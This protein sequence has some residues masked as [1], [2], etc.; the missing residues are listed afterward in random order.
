MLTFKTAQAADIPQLVSL[1]RRS[2]FDTEE[3]VLSFI[4]RF[5]IDT[6][7]AGE[8][9][10]SIVC[11]GYVLPTGG[12]HTQR[13]VVSC[14]YIYALAV[15]PEQRGRGFG[16]ELTRAAVRVSV[17]RGFA[18]TALRPSDAGLFDFYRALGFS[19]LFC[20]ENM[21]F[22]RDALPASVS[23][24]KIAPL[25]PAEYLRLRESAL[26]GKPHLAPAAEGVAFQ[27]ALGALYGFSAEECEGCAA[28]E[29]DGARADI[30]EL[31]LSRGEA[32]HAVK[33]ISSAVTAESFHVRCPA[34]DGGEP[35][36]M[37]FPLPD[38]KLE[39]PFLG[40]S[41]D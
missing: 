5:G 20:A 16:R 36:G 27:A 31:I 2:F 35:D 8:L 13:G 28:I 37:V 26:E 19:E 40:L 24:G 18:L 39:S 32:A 34:F 22:E 3:L 23:G 6:C 38:I 11:A 7:V 1:W 9:D 14:S 29:A 4:R 30:K 17:E 25:S 12:L 10:G 41:F 33:L 15:N 21:T